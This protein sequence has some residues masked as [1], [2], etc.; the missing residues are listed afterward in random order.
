MALDA[1][2]A[3]SRAGSLQSARR[4]IRL[5]GFTKVKSRKRYRCSQFR[6]P[7]VGNR[8]AN[9]LIQP[10]PDRPSAWAERPT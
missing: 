8:R 5:P 10:G 1:I 9:C 4:G 6:R 3:Q 7:S 2:V